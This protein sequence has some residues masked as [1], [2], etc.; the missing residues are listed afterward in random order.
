MYL[1]KIPQSTYHQN[2]KNCGVL[3]PQ[4]RPLGQEA[5]LQTEGLQGKVAQ[6]WGKYFAQQSIKK[7]GKL[8]RKVGLGVSTVE[9]NRDRDVSTRRDVF[10]QTVKIFSTVKISVFEMSRLRVSIKIKAKIKISRHFRVI[11][12]I[13]TWGFK[14]QDFL[15]MLR[16]HF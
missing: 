11:K 9:S 16:C 12:I 2:V 3:S 1:H 15:D 10:F 7:G 8:E 5:S 13:E 4:W 6:R 14:C